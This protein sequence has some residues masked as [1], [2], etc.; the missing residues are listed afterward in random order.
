MPANITPTPVVSAI[1]PFS[2]PFMPTVPTAK[3]ESAI[4]VR[5]PKAKRAPGLLSKA[6]RKVV[7]EDIGDSDGSAKMAASQSI[8]RPPFHPL[9]PPAHNM[10]PLLA[11]EPAV[12]ETAQ[13]PEETIDFADYD[14]D[15][16]DL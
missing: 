11:N 5:Q 15:F 12:W 8:R 16:D 6:S 2:M 9:N 7:V 13:L 3:P 4:K 1:V 14:D 10:E